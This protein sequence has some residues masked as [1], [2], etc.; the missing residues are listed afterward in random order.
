V[1]VIAA[2]EQS[3]MRDCTGTV[4]ANQDSVRAANATAALSKRRRTV[5]TERRRYIT[6]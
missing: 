1:T 5:L 6:K 4:T 3:V 2:T